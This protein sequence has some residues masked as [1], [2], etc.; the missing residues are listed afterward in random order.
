MIKKYE[1]FSGKIKLDTQEVIDLINILFEL[2]PS[3][4]DEF[5]TKSLSKL[6]NNMVTY[7]SEDDKFEIAVHFQESDLYIDRY[8][9]IITGKYRTIFKVRI[10]KIEGGMKISDIKDYIKLTSDIIMQSYDDVTIKLLFDSTKYN[11]EE[12]INLTDKNI[13]DIVFIIKIV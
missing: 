4:P 3:I 2:K 9:N 7:K 5:P 11:L 10:N 8:G 6:A 13:D 12:F 1:N